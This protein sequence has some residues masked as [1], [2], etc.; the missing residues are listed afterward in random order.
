MNLWENIALAFA[1]LKAN[2]MRAFLTMLGIIIGISSVITITTLGGIM[3]KSVT[4]T[5]DA[6]GTTLVQIGLH[7]KPDADRDYFEFG[8]FIS[9]EMIEEFE[10]KFEG[11]VTSVSMLDGAGSGTVRVN[12]ENLSV[13]IAGVSPGSI[14]GSMTELVKGR[15]ITDKDM[16]AYRQVCVISEKQAAKIYGDENPI[17]KIFTFTYNSLSYDFTVVGVYKSSMSKLMSAMVNMTGEDWDTTIYIPVTTA[18]LMA[19]F[20]DITSVGYFYYFTF[21]GNAD[22]SVPE[23]AADAV[24][25][26]NTRY[27]RDN[28][29]VEVMSYTAEQELSMFSSMIGIVSTVITIIAGISLLVGG[30]GVM[31]I[32]LVSVTERTREIGVRKALGATNGSIRMQFITESMIICLIG[33]VIGILLGLLLGNIVGMAIGMT[34]PASVSAIIIAVTFSM[35]IGVFFGY[36]PANKAAKYDPIEA[37]RYE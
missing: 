12:R 36:Y 34:A 23:L 21:M 15:Y 20:G 28:D 1:S 4:D 9:S 8:D 3:E 31:N 17:G 5:Y 24:E 32:M 29:A 30:I 26:F 10:R 13:D 27:Y 25:F 2:K 6:L 14:N 7:T 22:E 19:S 18:Q 11:R 16:D 33:G 37:L 35:A